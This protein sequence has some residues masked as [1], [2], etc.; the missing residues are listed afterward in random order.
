MVFS[1]TQKD[2]GH[3]GFKLSID[4]IVDLCKNESVEANLAKADSKM[5]AKMLLA[6][7]DIK[8]YVASLALL[9]NSCVSFMA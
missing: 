5:I 4:G 6:E 8:P 7:V 3:K 1:L 2:Q 9:R